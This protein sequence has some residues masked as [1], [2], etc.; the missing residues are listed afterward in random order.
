MEREKYTP[1]HDLGL[2]H[3]WY[4]HAGHL[5][6]DE[7]GM[8]NE[9]MVNKMEKIIPKYLQLAFVCERTSMS[10]W[11]RKRERERERE[12]HVQNYYVT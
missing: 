1:G 3:H 6:E 9:F 12:L 4:Q 5:L 2:H 7:A 8:I 10:G 11:E